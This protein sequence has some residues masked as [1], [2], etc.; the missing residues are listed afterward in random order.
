MRNHR[1]RDMGGGEE[2]SSWEGDKVE[3]NERK[4]REELSELAKVD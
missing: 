4:L 3:K 2:R 1:R